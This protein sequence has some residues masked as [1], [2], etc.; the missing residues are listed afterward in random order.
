MGLPPHL[1]ALKDLIQ[2]F[3]SEMTLGKLAKELEALE[4]ELKDLK[5]SGAPPQSTPSQE[6]EQ[7]HDR[8]FDVRKS[9]GYVVGFKLDGVPSKYLEVPCVTPGCRNG[10]RRQ[11]P[12]GES[13]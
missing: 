13:R 1:S 7:A 11:E 5:Q 8:A 10:F 4:K 2:P 6:G 12:G 3:S 9:L